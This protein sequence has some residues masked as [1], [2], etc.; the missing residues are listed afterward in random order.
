MLPRREDS[1]TARSP[2]HGQHAASTE[3][4]ELAVTLRLVLMRHLSCAT[5]LRQMERLAS[6]RLSQREIRGKCL[7]LFA[8]LRQDGEKPGGLTNVSGPSRPVEPIVKHCC[9][10]DALFAMRGLLTFSS[11][12]CLDVV[13]QPVPLSGRYG[14]E[15]RQRAPF[16]ARLGNTNTNC[17]WLV[18]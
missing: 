10:T 13:A 1:L 2:N 4:E 5:M 6:C 16:F 14:N 9:E 18:T 15:N 11:I 3:P 17:H 8:A 12:A 7:R